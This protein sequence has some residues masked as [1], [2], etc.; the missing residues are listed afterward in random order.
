MWGGVIGMV[1]GLLF[2]G[3]G[4]TPSVH[5][6]PHIESSPQLSP[7][8]NQ[9][10]TPQAN[11]QGQINPQIQQNPVQHFGAPQTNIYINSSVQE[12]ASSVR[13][14]GSSLHA[15][16][17]QAV[18]AKQENN[19]E[20]K[21]SAELKQVK[22]P[23]ISQS[24]DTRFISLGVGVAAAVAAVVFIKL[25]TG[26]DLLNNKQAWLAWKLPPIKDSLPKL[27]L[28]REI[29]DRYFDC[30]KDEADVRPLLGLFKHDLIQEEE[31]LKSYMSL[32]QFIEKWRLNWIF[33]SQKDGIKK[34]KEGLDY[35]GKL[36]E[37]SKGLVYD[38]FKNKP[39]E[40]VL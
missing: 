2:G 40:G 1:I 35:L 21:N 38:Q 16:A 36:R 23:I 18:H 27:V 4:Q 10:F 28:L 37:L 9:N 25:K 20:Q 11:T 3:G 5:Q 30:C 31:Q 19:S 17:H 34:A 8:Q 14:G 13:I 22:T 12:K 7:Q 6:Q 33:C 15:A 24:F 39:E 29:Y 32:A 26:Q